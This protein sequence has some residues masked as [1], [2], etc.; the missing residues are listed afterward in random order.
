MYNHRMYRDKLKCVCGILI[1]VVQQKFCEECGADI[2][3]LN[4]SYH[5]LEQDPEYLELKKKLDE[6]EKSFQRVTEAKIKEE[7]RNL[8]YAKRISELDIQINEKRN[9][10]AEK[11]AWVEELKGE[12][13]NLT[14]D[15]E[16]LMLEK[17]RHISGPGS[18]SKTDLNSGDEFLLKS[19]L[20]RDE[21]LKRQ[22]EDFEQ[23]F[24]KRPQG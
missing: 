8:E 22:Q 16:S 11:S 15:L 6:K 4:D 24:G 2:K 12:I 18:A 14:G 13:D 20:L 19:R 3:I 9:L 5:Q 17:K 7:R 10:I 23:T 1:D 21:Y